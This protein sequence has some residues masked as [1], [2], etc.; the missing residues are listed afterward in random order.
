MINGVV[1]WLNHHQFEYR[2]N[3][4]SICLGISVKVET[5]QTLLDGL[6]RNIKA[7][8]TGKRLKLYQKALSGYARI[9]LNSAKDASGL[10]V[11]QELAVSL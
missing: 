5:L 10:D 8:R 1:L 9:F 6:G 4:C 3:I 11:P 7:N 2:P